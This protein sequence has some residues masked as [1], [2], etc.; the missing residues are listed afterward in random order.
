MHWSCSRSCLVV[1][2]LLLRRAEGDRSPLAAVWLGTVLLGVLFIVSAFT[3]FDGWDGGW[4]ALVLVLGL[5]IGAIAGARLGRRMPSLV[6]LGAIGIG[7]PVAIPAALLFGLLAV[8]GACF[9]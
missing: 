7:T 9:D 4:A 2:P 8:T 6:A 1:P 5:I 3:V